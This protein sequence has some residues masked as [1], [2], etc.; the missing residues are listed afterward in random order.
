MYI[1]LGEGGLLKGVGPEIIA[2]YGPM[3]FMVP[4]MMVSMRADS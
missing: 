1:Q 3:I 4:N 2:I